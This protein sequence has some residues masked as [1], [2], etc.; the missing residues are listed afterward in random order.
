M[1]NSVTPFKTP[2]ISRK[3][4]NTQ[5][6]TPLK[7]NESSEFIQMVK[8]QEEL[9]NESAKKL[10]KFEETDKSLKIEIESLNDLIS[11]RNLQRKE[12]NLKI[13]EI[14]QKNEKLEEEIKKLTQQNFVLSKSK[15][16]M[17]FILESYNNKE[18]IQIL[19]S[20][21]HGKDS[22][23]KNNDQQQ[24]LK[25][26]SM[27]EMQ[28]SLLEKN[29]EENVKNNLKSQLKL[30]QE[31]EKLKRQD[32]ECFDNNHKLTS[33]INELK[34][35]TKKI[36]KK[37]YLAN[38]QLEEERE[39]NL[40]FKQKILLLESV[41]SNPSLA[42]SVSTT[43]TSSLFDQLSEK[44]LQLEESKSELEKEKEKV[45]FLFYKYL[46]CF[47]KNLIKVSLMEQEIFQNEKELLKSINQ[48][49]KN[50]IEHFD[51]Q[52]LSLDPLINLINDSKNSLTRMTSDLLN[53]QI[54][55]HQ[56]NLKKIK[57]QNRVVFSSLFFFVVL[58]LA[59]LFSNK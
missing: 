53:Q 2:K 4:Q 25:K 8:E 33:T 35:N 13:E 6:I 11:Q 17:D 56:K 9:L 37:L 20:S 52:N 10:K 45:I 51:H 29:C 19:N 44:S 41:Q 30:T 54:S 38:K 27:L 49:E 3:I 40:A 22:P 47:Y 36:A 48:A 59:I 23:L 14:S 43:T 7:F 26:I 57:I 58:M 16:E 42:S 18:N 28:V 15:K 12:D 39:L 55:Q 32:K 1:E 21:T 46:F 5:T 24:N 50:D 34:N 31:I